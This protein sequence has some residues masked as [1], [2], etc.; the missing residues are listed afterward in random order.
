MVIHSA[1]G[2]GSDIMSRMIADTMA[3][4]KIVSQPI[5]VVNK[6]G[7]SSAVATAYVYEKKGN[8]YYLYTVTTVHVAASLKG[9][10]KIKVQD[11]T[12]LV[13]LAA[14][15]ESIVVSA[16]SPHK[17]L[18][19]LIEASKVKGSR[20]TQA[21]A[22]LT[23]S[24]HRT[25]FVIKKS[26]GGDWE[27][28]SYKSGGE[29]LAAVL[30]GHNNFCVSNPIEVM[31]QLRAGTVRVLA[32]TGEKRLDI[33]PNVPTLKELN[34]AEPPTGFRA[35]AMPPGVP[36]EAVT[37]WEIAFKKFMTTSAWKTY[38]KENALLEA[39]MDSKTFTDYIN[40]AAPKF[41]SV[42]KEMGLLK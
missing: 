28:V 31:E 1:A 33:W 35:Y 32:V 2:G 18:K 14:D 21:G 34:I 42:M 40:T 8:P 23:G 39:W 6:P 26:T 37:Y 41:E 30:G 22:S 11:L 9:D 12:P 4:E 16:K 36:R 3:K 27:F 10:S 24:D 7:G 29:A 15:Q 5:T 38:V 19:E 20:M 17:T 25:G 13:S